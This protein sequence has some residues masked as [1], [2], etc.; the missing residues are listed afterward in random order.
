MLQCYVSKLTNYEAKKTLR[1]TPA[2][3][4]AGGGGGEFTT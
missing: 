1:M 4:V 2:H 3:N